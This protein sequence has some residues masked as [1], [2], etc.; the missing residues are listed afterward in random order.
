MLVEIKKRFSNEIILAGEY[1]NIRDAVEKN[2]SNLRFSDLSNSDLSNSNL[3]NSNLRYSNLSNSN[4]SN[5]NLSCSDLSCSDLSCSDLSGSDL[6][7]SDL[8]GSDLSGSNLNWQSHDLI[9]EILLRSAGDDYEKRSIAG[10]ILISRDWC[11]DK[12]VALPV[13]NEIITWFIDTLAPFAE[14]SEPPKEFRCLCTKLSKSKS[15]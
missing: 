2:K 15:E 4:L 14:N 8:S 9:A 12:F 6:S 13:S 3:S 1:E 5:S 11:W 7:G 10:L